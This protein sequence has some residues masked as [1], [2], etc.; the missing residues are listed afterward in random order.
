MAITAGYSILT[1]QSRCEMV[2]VPDMI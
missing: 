1:E 2:D